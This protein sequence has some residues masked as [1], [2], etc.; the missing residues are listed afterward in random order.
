MVTIEIK[1]GRRNT[2]KTVRNLQDAY[3]ESLNGVKTFI[4]DVNEEYNHFC[5]LSNVYSTKTLNDYLLNSKDLEPKIYIPNFLNKGE[6]LMNNLDNFIKYISSFDK[7]PKTVI[8]EDINKFLFD[9]NGKDILKRL[10]VTHRQNNIK[11]ILTFQTFS[12]AE[13]YLEYAHT[14]EVFKTADDFLGKSYNNYNLIKKAIELV[15]NEN[16]NIK[17]F[18]IKLDLTKA[19]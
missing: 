11:Y 2:G 7:D 4:Y 19:H 15:K 5:K 6:N 3:C 12:S 18:S 10:L 16:E 1:V 14:I 13:K 9:K 17:S 8:L